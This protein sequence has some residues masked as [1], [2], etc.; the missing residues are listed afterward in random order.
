M[1]AEDDELAGD[2]DGVGTL[3]PRPKPVEVEEDEEGLL[4]AILLGLLLDDDEV[5]EAEDLSLLE[6]FSAVLTLDPTPGKSLILILLLYSLS[7]DEEEE[8][9]PLEDFLLDSSEFDG[10]GEEDDFDELLE[11]EVD[12]L[13]FDDELFDEG[14]E[15]DVAELSLILWMIGLGSGFA[16]SC[17]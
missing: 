17:F 14:M 9:E 6:S 4:L 10:E 12:P 15:G 13:G 16:P 8:E 2:E 7:P 1:F 11:D 5:L 3:L